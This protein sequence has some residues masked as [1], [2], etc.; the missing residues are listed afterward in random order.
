[1]KKCVAFKGRHKYLL[2]GWVYENSDLI[3]ACPK[4][5]LGQSLLLSLAYIAGLLMKK[6]GRGMKVLCYLCP[7]MKR[8]YINIINKWENH[9]AL[10]SK[11]LA[12]NIAG[13]LDNTFK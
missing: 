1:M 13:R 8:Q 2:V 3:H 7:W 9:G 5:K 10:K 6:N 12:A 11:M 4:S